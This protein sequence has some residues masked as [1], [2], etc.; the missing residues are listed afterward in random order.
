MGEKVEKN[1]RKV[2]TRNGWVQQG[3]AWYFERI[4]FRRPEP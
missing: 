3:K 4:F 2:T 1:G